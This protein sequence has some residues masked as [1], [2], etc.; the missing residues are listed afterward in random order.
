MWISRQKYLFLTLFFC[1]IQLAASS[2]HGQTYRNA[3][4][5]LLFIGPMDYQLP[6]GPSKEEL[7]QKELEERMAKMEL[8]LPKLLFKSYL[9]PSLKK[10]GPNSLIALQQVGEQQSL[11]G[12]LLME[13]ERATLLEDWDNAADLQN[14]LACEYFRMGSLNHAFSFFERALTLKTELNDHNDIAL[15][16]FNLAAAYEF[17]EDYDC[18]RS[19]FGSVY[20]EAKRRGNKL[21]QGYAMMHMAQVKSKVGS[22]AEAETDLIQTILPLFKSLKSPLGEAGRLETYYTLSNVYMMQDRYPESQWF[23]LQARE[24][25]EKQGFKSWMPEII[26]SL[27]QVKKSSGNFDVAILEYNEASELAQNEQF[28][29]MQLA[30][31]DA[32]GYIYNESGKYK[33]ALEALNRYDSL[34]NQV[35]S[36]EFPH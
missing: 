31:Q 20:Q 30:I 10:T 8:E 32:L 36:M 17:T 15:I 21:Q 4:D 7:M 6:P 18:A 5:S 2:L 11:E 12:W 34:K 29:V 35:I 23:L 26:F 25:A 3:Q 16:K 24:I 9:L 22:Y 27:A 1:V 14:L 33:E 13:I 28:L 19:L